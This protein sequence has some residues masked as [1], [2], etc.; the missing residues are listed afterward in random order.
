LWLENLSIWSKDAMTDDTLIGTVREEMARPDPRE[1]LYLA[2]RTADTIGAAIAVW[3]LIESL[4]PRA[5]VLTL[6]SVG[7]DLSPIQIGQRITV[8]WRGQPVFI[9]HPMDPEAT[10]EPLAA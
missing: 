2:T 1:F 3:P 10:R 6:S 4:N 8:K 9:N 7:V 5:E